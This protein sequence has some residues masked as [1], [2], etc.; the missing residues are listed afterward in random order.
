MHD[1]YGRRV[2][3]LFGLF[4]EGFDTADLK[5]AKALL[6][7]LKSPGK[8]ARG[9]ALCKIAQANLQPNV[10]SRISETSTNVCPR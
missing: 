7:E 6:D 9:H 4:I 8:P 10:P 1:S 3:K 2:H 5:D